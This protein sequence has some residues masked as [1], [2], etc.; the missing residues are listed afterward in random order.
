M[1]A[2]LEVQHGKWGQHIR[3]SEMGTVLK[4][5]PGMLWTVAGATNVAYPCT[6]YVYQKVVPKLVTDLS[7]IAAILG[8]YIMLKVCSQ[9]PIPMPWQ[10]DAPAAAPLY[11]WHAPTKASPHP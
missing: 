8:H 2:I 3:T 10:K 5:M 6:N 11:Q 4:S 9:F 7:H 1:G